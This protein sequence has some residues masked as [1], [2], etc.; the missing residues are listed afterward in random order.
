MHILATRKHSENK[1]T[2]V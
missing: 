1:E 2:I